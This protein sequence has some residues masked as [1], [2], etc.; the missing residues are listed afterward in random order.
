MYRVFSILEHFQF[1]CLGTLYAT[2][3]GSPTVQE[4]ILIPCCIC[5]WHERDLLTRPETYTRRILYMYKNDH[6]QNVCNQ[7]VISSPLN[8]II[9]SH[10]W[11]ECIIEEVCLSPT[12]NNNN[13][14]RVTSTGVIGLSSSKYRDYDW[15]PICWRDLSVSYR[16][17]FDSFVISP[18]CGGVHQPD[19]FIFLGL[20]VLHHDL[21]S[22]FLKVTVGKTVGRYVM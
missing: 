16:V 20:K 18:M 12:L 2:L 8:L 15:E 21:Q 3:D 11:A 9:Y 14:V 13:F 19:Y 7:L 22:I 1:N 5:S 4:R 10:P 6:N 17:S